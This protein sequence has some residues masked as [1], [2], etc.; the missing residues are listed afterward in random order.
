[1]DSQVNHD[2]TRMKFMLTFTIIPVVEDAELGDALKR[3]GK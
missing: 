1:M 2:R 3:A